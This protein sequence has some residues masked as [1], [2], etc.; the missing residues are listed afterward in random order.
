MCV[1]HDDSDP[2]DIPHANDGH[3]PNTIEVIVCMD[4]NSTGHGN[5]RYPGGG[6]GPGSSYLY[7]YENGYQRG[8]D[9][10]FRAGFDAA[11]D[12][13]YPICSDGNY[14]PHPIMGSDVPS[15]IHVTV[16]VN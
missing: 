7:G 3:P 9:N 13:S 5:Y 15:S 12:G 8:Y 10:G 2:W 1:E 16:T 4:P 6:Q 11:R 14:S